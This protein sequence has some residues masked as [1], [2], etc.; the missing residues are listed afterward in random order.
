MAENDVKQQLD[1]LGYSI[2][3][4][5]DN[6][7]YNITSLQRTMARIESKL[8]E[9]NSNINKIGSKVEVIDAL[10]FKL[11]S[12]VDQVN[13]NIDKIGSKVEVI[14]ALIYKLG[15]ENLDDKA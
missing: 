11:G 12:E 5:Q 10:I 3:N 15:A 1:E 14:D 13:S 6:L 4:L 7:Q 9:A 8:D 2:R